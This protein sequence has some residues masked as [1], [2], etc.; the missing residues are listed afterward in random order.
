[1]R[2]T[3][4]SVFMAAAFMAKPVIGA[5]NDAYIELRGERLMQGRST[6]LANCEG[7]HGY[8]IA[9][10]PI[11]MQPSEW[12][13]RLEKGKTVL[14]DHAINGFFGPDDTLMPARGGNPQL[15][16]QEVMV[17]VDYMTAL[18]AYYIQLERKQYDSRTSATR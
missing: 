10:A 13:P 3:V 15:T 8:G 7:C 12:A 14:Y 1:M 16:D 5:G 2:G 11:P 17:A 6:W 18:A 9:D 4:Y